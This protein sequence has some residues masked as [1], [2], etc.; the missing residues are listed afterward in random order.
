MASLV[1][2]KEERVGSNE[3]LNLTTMDQYPPGGSTHP[4]KPEVGNRD[5]YSN[6][7][8]LTLLS[9]STL[10]GGFIN[11]KYACIDQSPVT[12]LFN[13]KLWSLIKV[14]IMQETTLWMFHELLELFCGWNK[15]YQKPCL[16]ELWYEDS[17]LIHNHPHPIPV[18][19]GNICY[20]SL[21][22]LKCRAKLFG[23]AVANSGFRVVLGVICFL[24]LIKKP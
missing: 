18:L 21:I 2:G 17:L 24:V 3:K 7:N 6:Y 5:I 8:F 12:R 4:H 13:I 15:K 22:R 10:V 9:R 14:S 20:Y 23:A 1:N 11:N 16:G 19:L